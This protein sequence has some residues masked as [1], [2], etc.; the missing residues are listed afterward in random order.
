M[1]VDVIYLNVKNGNGRFYTIKCANKIIDDFKKKPLLF[2]MY[3]HD[4]QNYGVILLN[5]IS[6]RVN[7]IFLHN[8]I[9][10]ADISILNTEYGK[11]LSD[12]FDNMSFSTASIGS[13]DYDGYVNIEKFITINASL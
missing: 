9:L 10:W 8:N 4:E 6:H 11:M 1:I 12:N 2:G 3:E 13:V 7:N 5:K